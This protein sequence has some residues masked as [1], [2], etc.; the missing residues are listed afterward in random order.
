M[1]LSFFACDSNVEYVDE[2]TKIDSQV[3]SKDKLETMYMMQ[4]NAELILAD[5][6]ISKS[7][8]FVL[9]LSPE[10]AG[11]LQIPD[12]LYRKYIN[13]VN[14]LNKQNIN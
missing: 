7:T 8:G 3:A 5:R 6:I 14:E 2:E 1:S 9:D 10:E 12:E 4:S 11:E 13:K